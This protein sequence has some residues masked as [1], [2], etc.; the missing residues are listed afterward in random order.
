M[1]AYSTTTARN[2]SRDVQLVHDEHSVIYEVCGDGSKTKYCTSKIFDEVSLEEAT[3]DGYQLF[4]Q[5]IIFAGR[6]S[7]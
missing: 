6:S 1:S 2:S 4:V 7:L 5:N 3:S